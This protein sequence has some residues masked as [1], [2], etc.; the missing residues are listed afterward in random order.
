[1]KKTLLILATMFAFLTA[2]PAAVILNADSSYFLGYIVPGVAA[3]PV[4]EA[5]YITALIN[6]APGATSVV[7]SEADQLNSVFRTFDVLETNLPTPV[8]FTEKFNVGEGGFTAD[9]SFSLVGA[10]Y[11]LAKYGNYNRAGA[12]SL[13]WWV[14]GLGGQAQIGETSGLSHVS[15]F[16]PPVP[17]MSNVSENGTTLALMGIG[18]VGLFY[19]RRFV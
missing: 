6:T 13:V 19:F 11:V 1:M 12:V 4:S 16:D 7:Y 5:G 18:M 2:A 8:T 9:S 17:V 10:D 15:L 3:D 14:T